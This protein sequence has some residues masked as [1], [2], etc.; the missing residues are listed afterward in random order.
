MTRGADWLDLNTF[1]PAE[2]ALPRTRRLLNTWKCGFVITTSQCS[3]NLC[4]IKPWIE[5]FW[6]YC[7]DTRC[8]LTRSEYL[9]ACG[10][11]SAKDQKA[12]QHLEVRFCYYDKSMF[13][14]FM[15]NQ[16]MNIVFLILLL[17]HSVLTDQIWMGVRSTKDH[18]AAQHLE[19]RFCHYD[20]SMFWPFIPNQTMK[21][22]FLMLLQSHAR[23]TV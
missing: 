13:W 19:H 16:T 21:T 10:I 22:D 15:L 6:S 8:W 3:A 2:Y 14:P 1:P 20:K 9:S 17:W 23:L 18:K 12:P 11:C 5:T 7:G 4:W